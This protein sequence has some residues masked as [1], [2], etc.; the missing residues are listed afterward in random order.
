[1]HSRILISLQL[2]TLLVLSLDVV[3]CVANLALALAEGKYDL[4][5]QRSC[6]SSSTYLGRCKSGRGV[7]GCVVLVLVR[8]PD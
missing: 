8:K 3:V 5:G 4:L 6:S 1:M 7:C 2:L